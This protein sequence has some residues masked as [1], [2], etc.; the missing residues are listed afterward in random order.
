LRYAYQR[1]AATLSDAIRE[2][3][4]T[5]IQVSV[6]ARLRQSGPLTQNRLGR[7]LGMDPPNVRDVVQR[8][9]RRGLV[10]L[11]PVPDDRR[12][13]RVQA[14][15]AGAELFARVWPLAEAANERTLSI[16]TSEEQAL[17][18]DVL[19]RLAAGPPRA[20]AVPEPGTPGVA[21]LI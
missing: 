1:A 16:L 11:E 3:E 5:P 7:S 18:A 4:L 14:T 21:Q 9:A 6:L 19:A 10:S 13:L 8:L 2:F 15:P 17:L 20:L 12:A